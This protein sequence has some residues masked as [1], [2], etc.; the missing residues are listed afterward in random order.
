M[1]TKQKKLVVLLLAIILLLVLF[2]SCQ[3]HTPNVP[4]SPIKDNKPSDDESN[5]S[6]EIFS[7][8]E[9]QFEAEK[10]ILACLNLFNDNNGIITD[11]VFTEDYIYDDI[12]IK[13]GS[14]ASFS[15][16]S[17]S[18]LL[19]DYENI[20]ISLAIDN[21]GKPYK[22]EYAGSISGNTIKTNI[23]TGS[24]EYKSTPASIICNIYF[25]ELYSLVKNYS[26]GKEIS[27]EF[28]IY[29]DESFLDIWK[30]QKGWIVFSSNL[31]DEA[32][33]KI[34]FT[35]QNGDVS[36]LIIDGWCEA[37]KNSEGETE[38]KVSENPL[39]KGNVPLTDEEALEL[40]SMLNAFYLYMQVEYSNNP[41]PPEF[42]WIGENPGWEFELNNLYIPTF[43]GKPVYVSGTETQSSAGGIQFDLEIN[44]HKVEVSFSNDFSSS[45]IIDERN[46]SY[47]SDIAFQR[48]IEC[49]NI[50]RPLWDIFGYFLY[51]YDENVEMNPS[52]EVS[53]E[54]NYKVYEFKDTDLGT[55]FSPIL[56][57][58]LKV[59]EEDFYF[60]LEMKDIYYDYVI[61]LESSGFFKKE[62][63]C[64]QFKSLKYVETGHEISE[65]ELNAYN[66]LYEA[67]DDFESSY[68]EK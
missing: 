48:F 14:K 28:T 65:F 66:V 53:Q 7:I 9:E 42:E 50:I 16:V 38:L 64:P 45:I 5:T 10:A 34:N 60:I 56:N 3:N 24:S 22:V 35:F 44:D 17:N 6:T 13:K 31:F 67:F 18:R 49:Y 46:Y 52:Y 11:G 58:K 43:F 20:E 57:G 62:S 27:D 61:I 32:K 12:T 51:G 23:F 26:M 25:D 1:I 40:S 33:H 30:A 55:L 41:T 15:N 68:A 36:S 4:E 19:S 29:N 21:D 54:G 37:N 2:S 59:S 63:K 8:S 47:L 39:F